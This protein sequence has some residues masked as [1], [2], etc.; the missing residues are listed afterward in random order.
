[1][2]CMERTS[3]DPSIMTHVGRLDIAEA[4][5]TKLMDFMG[6]AEKRQWEEDREKKSTEKK[7]EIDVE[8]TRTPLSPLLCIIDRGGS[9]PS[10][11]HRI[12]AVLTA[13]H[14]ISTIDR[15]TKRQKTRG[16][17]HIAG[18]CLMILGL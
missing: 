16:S 3:Y 10:R 13:L 7:E 15:A 12:Q 5:R 1:V 9:H 8:M 17:E 2:T 14:L 6:A 18:R 11:P 4:I